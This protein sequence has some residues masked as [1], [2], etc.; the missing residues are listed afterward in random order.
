M[1]S[2]RE[3]TE[4]VTDYLEDRLPNEEKMSFQMHIGMCKSCRNYV[5]QMRQT[6]QVLGKVPEELSIPEELEDALRQHFRQWR[7]GGSASESE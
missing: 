6:V 1:I 2:C 3:L 4:L 5:S 7:A